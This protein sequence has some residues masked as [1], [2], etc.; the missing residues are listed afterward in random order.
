MA[1]KPKL[2]KNTGPHPR[3]TTRIA[4]ETTPTSLA[5]FETALRARGMRAD[6]NGNWTCPAHDDRV[7]SLSMR[8]A[9]DGRVLVR[10]HAGCETPAVVEALGLGMSDLFEGQR[11]RVE[12]EGI[13]PKERATAQR[14]GFTVADYAEWKRLPISFLN[15]IGVTDCKHPHYGPV[16]RISYNDEQGEEGTVRFRLMGRGND[17]FRWRKG[18]KPTLYGLDRLQAARDVGYVVLVEGE[19]DCHTLWYH[20]VPALGIPGVSTWRD[21]WVDFLEGIETVYVVVEPDE[22]GQKLALKLGTASSLRDRLRLVQLGDAKDASELHTIENENFEA[23][24]RVAL[25]A[26][27]PWSDYE[28]AAAETLRSEAWAI[29]KDLAHEENILDRFIEDLRQSGVVGEEC[30][31]KLIFLSLTSRLLPHPVSLAIKGP[32]SAGKSFTLERTLEFFPNSAYYALSAM[33]ERALA[34]SDEPVRHRMMIIYEAAG[35]VGDMASYLMRSLLSEGR[36]RYETVEKTK[37]GLQSRLIEREGPTGLIVTTTALRLHA[38]NETRLFSVPVNDTPEQT[39]A[40]LYRVAEGPPP[41][42]D[43]RPWHALQDWVAGG[44]EEVDIPFAP[45]L[46]KAIPATGV[47]LRRDFPAVLNLIRS[48]ALLHQASRARDTAGRIVATLDDYSAVHELVADLV[49]EGV[50]SAVSPT[51]RETVN[52]VSELIAA[53]KPIVSIADVAKQIGLDKSAAS[54]RVAAARRLGYLVNEEARK[55]YT[56]RLTLG[57]VM[58]EETEI[59]PPVG[60]LATDV[61]EPGDSYGGEADPPERCTVARESGE[62]SPLS[63]TAPSDPAMRDLYNI[64]DAKRG[65]EK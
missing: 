25:D 59:L 8:A 50:E 47:R 61:T 53:G 51:V 35:L 1:N 10:C 7:P 42:V 31:A 21:N 18:S 46:A 30:A 26:A 11:R 27:I 49:A 41:P 19:S 36:I 15:E 20:G 38:E 62:V 32:S 29:C 63:S 23:A 55:G 9:E 39:K 45:S 24:W 33:S 40:I 6:G 13:P 58:P 28:H 52:A 4:D 2:T 5:R 54:R 64:F 22:A 12:R 44:A 14:S 57:S 37:D 65:D 3:S 48:H 43:V 34:Y 56:A 17:R 16:V 60:A